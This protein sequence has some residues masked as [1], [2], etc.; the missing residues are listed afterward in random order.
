MNNDL[1]AKLFSEIRSR[2]PAQVSLVEEIATVLNI[3]S[4]S[5]YRRIRGEKV[6]SLEEGYALCQRYGFSL[7]NLYNP[8]SN[9]YV[10]TGNFV[11]T[12]SFNYK[13]YLTNIYQQVKYMNGFEHRELIYLAKDIPL[14]YHFHTRV[15]AAFKH[16]F[17]MRNILHHPDF[18][19][20]KFRADDFPEDFY[21]IGKKALDCY[22]NLDTIEIWNIESIN[23]TIRQVEYYHDTNVF[24][25]EEEIY[26][27]YEAVG[28]LIDH[29]EIQ[30][31]N[32]YKYALEGNSRQAMGKYE[33]YFNEIVI[34]ENSLL[35]ILNGGKTAF[36]VHNVI[37]VL[38]TRD[39]AFC[40]NM[41]SYIQNLMKKS[42]LISTVSER[43][44]TR[45]F[46]YLRNKIA[47]RKQSLKA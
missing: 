6:L 47:N 4:D 46:K 23:S 34:L 31:T 39:V 5:A 37:N 26:K 41:Y 24:T 25:S 38:I 14:F 28:K 42:T 22:N 16:Y 30:A 12:E 1:Q 40:D 32:G 33:M 27:V 8:S 36:L 15:L 29:L 17:W 43:E 44:R 20:K 3:S 13:E 19:S 11:K 21:E 45:F 7:D 2:L 18:A 10:F 35:A 9:S